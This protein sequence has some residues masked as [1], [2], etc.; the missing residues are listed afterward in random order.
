VSSPTQHQ[1]K[2]QKLIHSQL[3]IG[4]HFFWACP[5]RSQGPSLYSKFGS[6]NLHSPSLTLSHSLFTLSAHSLLPHNLFSLFSL[7]KT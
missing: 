2:R 3:S 1:K 7:P 4:I 6:T 5:F